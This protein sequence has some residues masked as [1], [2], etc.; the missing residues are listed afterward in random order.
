M[1]KHRSAAGR[2]GE[3]VEKVLGREFHKLICLGRGR[4]GFEGGLPVHLEGVGVALRGLKGFA[5][6]SG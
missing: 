1:L 6:L 4:F 3:E 5:G 2:E